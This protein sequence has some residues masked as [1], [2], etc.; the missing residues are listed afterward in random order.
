MRDQV[1]Q[2]GITLQIG[3]QIHLPVDDLVQ[4]ID[5]RPI[6]PAAE[7]QTGDLVVKH[8]DPVTVQ[9][10]PVFLQLFLDIRHQRQPLRKGAVDKMLV[11]LGDIQIDKGLYAIVT[12]VLY[13]IR[14]AKTPRTAS[15][16]P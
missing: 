5:R 11:E 14:L 6:V 12:I 7:I 16:S 3:A 9:V 10:D 2:P 8:Q 4:V 1:Q 13:D 15:A